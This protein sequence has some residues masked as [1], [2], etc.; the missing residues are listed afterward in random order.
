MGLDF[1]GTR[2]LLYAQ[3]LGVKYENTIMIGRQ[4]L[5]LTKSELEDNLQAFGYSIEPKSLNDIY[6]KGM[7]Y[8]ELLFSYLGAKNIHSLDASAYERATNIH[9]MNQPIPSEYMEKYSVVLDGG[10]IEHIFNFPTAIKNCM[11]MLMVGGHYLG[12]T[13]ANNFMGH[14]FYQFSPELYFSVFTQHN[15]FEL[16]SLVTFEDRPGSTW[17]LVK[18]PKEVKNR[19]LLVNDQP[20]YL[21]VVAKKI[22][23]VNIFD[24]IPQQSDYLSVWQ[25]TGSDSTPSKLLNNRVNRI[26]FRNWL[27]RNLPH[28]A[29]HLIRNTIQG[30]GFNSNIFIPL[31]PTKTKSSIK[32]QSA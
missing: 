27:K 4:S 20:V 24:T 13:P 29:R 8:A 6:N 2:F 22:A 3:R 9:D 7:G 5:D 14:G 10:S 21:L 11:E 26:S 18:S 17:Y 23:K 31:D 25:S 30:H 16:V 19:V 15:G 28:K 32:K 12:I 1:N